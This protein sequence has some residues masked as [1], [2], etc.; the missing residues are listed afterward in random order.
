M[1]RQ[2]ISPDTIRADI[3]E[4]GVRKGDV[5]FIAADL[6]RVG[7]HAGSR[8]KTLAFWLDTLLDI[9]GPEGTLIIPSYTKSFP[10]WRKDPECVFSFG[11]RST[12]GALSE[13]FSSHPA[14]LRSRHPTNSCFGIGPAAQSILKDHDENAS[15]YLPYQ[16]IISMGGKNLMLGAVADEK[17]APMAI[18][19]AQEYLGITRK[20]WQSGLIQSFYINPQNKIKLFTRYDVGG[21]TSF[22]YKTI[23]H[24]LVSRAINIVKVGRSW[25]AYIDCRKSFELVCDIYKKQHHLLKCDNPKCRDCFGSPPLRHPV[26]WGKEV[27]LKFRN[28]IS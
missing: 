2:I 28:R 26:F 9:V 3:F 25:S 14:V 13:A 18:H 7:Y 12:S 22:G 23:G 16:K 20:N 19:A 4:L 27:L 6:M 15:S 10:R 11:S 8:E 21:C 17:L 5:V 1:P 24:H